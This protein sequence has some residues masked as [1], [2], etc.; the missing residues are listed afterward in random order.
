MLNNNFSKLVKLYREYEKKRRNQRLLK[1]FGIVAIIGTAWFLYDQIATKQLVSD[2]VVQTTSSESS[3][4]SQSQT[5]QHREN[6]SSAN[7]T[8]PLKKTAV[9]T[10]KTD[11]MPKQVTKRKPSRKREEPFQLKV[12][13]RESL[14][15]LLVAYKDQKSYSNAIKI[16]RFYLEEK[17]YEKAVKWAVEASKKDPT[18]ADSWIVYAQAK[19]ALGKTDVAKR[20]LSIFLK[21]NHSQTAQNL[22]DSL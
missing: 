8:K 9:E 14:Y 6:R 21:H 15:K 7:E 5:V 12:K 17:E 11:S 2:Q 18:K 16:A 22:L 3:A 13:Q 19:K 1:L 20:A 10:P 4:Q